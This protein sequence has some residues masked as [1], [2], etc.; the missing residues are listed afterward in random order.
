MKRGEDVEYISVKEAAEK[1]SVTQRAVQKW[2]KEGKIAGAQKFS[3]SWL[4]PSDFSLKD[5][6][7]SKKHTPMLLMNSSYE[8]GSALEFVNSIKDDDDRTLAL[9]E[10][11]YYIG[12]PDKTIELVQK[13]LDNTDDVLKYWATLL[14]LFSSMAAGKGVLVSFSLKSLSEQFDNSFNKDEKVTEA[15]ALAVFTSATVRTLLDIPINQNIPNIQNY[16]YALPDGIKMQACY[17]MAHRAYLEKEYVKALTIADVAIC[18]SPKK[19]PIAEIYVHIVAVMALMKLK[20]VDEAKEHMKRA[21][22]LAKK[23]EIIEP[24]IEH[25]ALLQGMVEVFFKKEY[26]EIYKR[27]VDGVNVFQDVWRT[28]HNKISDNSVTSK[29]STTEFII[30]MLYGHGWSVKEVASH[31]ELSPRT[32]NNY[33]STIY[34]KLYINNR[35]ALT[36]YILK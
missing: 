13:Y 18:L 9:A 29:L 23:D 30:A 8:L 17:I 6:A 35:K 2:A 16:I 20:R 34:S 32:V 27:I 21:W 5:D 24:F 19:F 11:Y 22:D 12:Q 14:C 15:H 31:M 3:G 10:Y 33:I 28:I 1:L 25:H 36:Q 26:P 7:P 4:I